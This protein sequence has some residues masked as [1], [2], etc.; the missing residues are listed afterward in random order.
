MDEDRGRE[1]VEEPESPNLGEGQACVQVGNPVQHG[2]YAEEQDP[3]EALGVE[4]E[5]CHRLGSG[6]AR[7]DQTCEEQDPQS[8][9][10][11]A[12]PEQTRSC[13]VHVCA[14]RDC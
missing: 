2:G 11:V 6:E 3:V 7:H 4:L 12:Q 14:S 10:E 9:A 13:E 1:D 8:P 5:S